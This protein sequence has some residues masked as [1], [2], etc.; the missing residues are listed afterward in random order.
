MCIYL[1][2]LWYNI[3]NEPFH[4]IF[5]VIFKIVKYSQNQT[6]GLFGNWSNDITDDLI[7]PDGNA[8][9]SIDINN[10]ENLHQN[11]GIKCNKMT[12]FQIIKFTTCFL[13]RAC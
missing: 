2:V 11:F 9:P 4:C 8:G 7:L 13:V 1:H 5:V 6:R 3:L 10:L 12:A